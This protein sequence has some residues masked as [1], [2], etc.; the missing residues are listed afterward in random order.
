MEAK[1]ENLIKLKT[2]EMPYGKYKGTVLIDLPEHY[3]VW[4]YENQLPQ[5]ELG[6]LFRELY[7]IKVNGLE[8]LIRSL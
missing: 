1:P 7:E 3:V 6:R 5:G 8:A 4:T 2:M